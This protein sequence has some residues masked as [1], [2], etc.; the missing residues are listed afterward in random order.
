VDG[1]IQTLHS[2]RTGQPFRV[3]LVHHRPAREDAPVARWFY[4]TLLPA[5][6]RRDFSFHRF[7]ET[8]AH[9]Y[10][11]VESR[12]GG[13][14]A[15]ARIGPPNSRLRRV[16]HEPV[17][18][19]IV[20]VELL[21]G[22]AA[23]VLGADLSQLVPDVALSELWGAE[24]LELEQSLAT[25]PT[26]SRV[27]VL[28]RKLAGR[29]E[30]VRSSSRA[31]RIGAIVG[32]LER[33]S[34]PSLARRMQ[35]SPRQLQ[36]RWRRYVGMTPR[37]YN[38]LARAQR[39]LTAIAQFERV[40]WKALAAATGYADQAHLVREFDAMMGIAPGQLMRA[41]DFVPDVLP[42]GWLV[43]PRRRSQA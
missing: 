26:A 15:S 8:A 4:S 2:R 6:S 36:R 35:C 5:D 38:R 7:P 40:D 37:T 11:V 22:A 29:F 20:G 21:P 23:E 33:L 18:A 34:I 27:A 3:G 30:G 42:A 19:H 12:A 39:V 28:E 13:L 1:D 25:A 31:Q 9:L 43:V 10:V 17:P 14:T 16:H 41:I 32:D 24:A